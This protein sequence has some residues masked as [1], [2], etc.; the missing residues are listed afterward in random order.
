M[1]IAL[2]I[3]LVVA[4]I[5]ILVAIGLWFIIQGPM[6]SIRK[7]LKGQIIIITGANTG[8]GKETAKYLAPLGPT[9]IMACRD[10]SRTLPAI[11]EIIKDSKNENVLFMKLDLSSLESIESF[12]EE[13][14]KKYDHLD[15][16]VNN[17]GIITKSHRLHYDLV[18]GHLMVNHIGPFHLTNLLMEKL[19][20]AAEPR[21]VNVSSWGHV[22][23]RLDFQDMNWTRR[24]FKAGAAY[25]NSKLY[26]I[27]HAK[28]L[29]RRENGRVLAFSLHPGIVRTELFKEH[30]EALCMKVLVCLMYPV[31][32]YSLKSPA[33]GA[34]TTNFLCLENKEKLE[35]GG[36]YS[37]SRRVACSSFGSD[38]R[39]AKEL[40]RVSEDLINQIKERN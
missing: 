23:A 36:Y 38:A 10:F 8:L 25:G 16:L 28:E 14:N 7:A 3:G 37:K 39:N 30:T 22:S 4:L 27:L 32:L 35:N 2:I 15:I 18:E 29:V 20:A 26:N 12:V 24:A 21:V 19:K 34:A 6:C 40:W 5:V 9:I 33:R 11:Q 1:E 31:L 13:F 17:A